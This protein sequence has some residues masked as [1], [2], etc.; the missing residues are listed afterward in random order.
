M[1]VQ[2]YLREEIVFP[3]SHQPKKK[4]TNIWLRPLVAN[5]LTDEGLG[6][7]NSYLKVVKNMQ[8]D[9]KKIQIETVQH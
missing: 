6:L 4:Q 7:L 9:E 8:K 3:A 5:S 2:S 1:G